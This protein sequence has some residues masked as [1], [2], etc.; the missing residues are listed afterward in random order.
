[1]TT[2]YTVGTSNGRPVLIGAYGFVSTAV[3]LR[4]GELPIGTTIEIRHPATAETCEHC[5][6]ALEMMPGSTPD[7]LYCEAGCGV[8][9]AVAEGRP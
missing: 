2:T 5:G 4:A 7:A 8:G 6:A 9:E 3:T 1:V